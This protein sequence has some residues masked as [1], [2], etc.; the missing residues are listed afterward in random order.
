MSDPIRLRPYRPGDEDGI[1]RCYNA[2]FPTAD[3][4]IRERAMASW[5]WRFLANPVPQVHH[6]VAEHEQEGIVGGYAGIPVRVWCEGEE[7]LATQNVDLMVL[8]QWRRAGPRPGLFVSLGKLF[9]ETFCGVA[10]DKALFCYGWPVPAWRMG[11]A[12]LGYWN[13]RDWD[14]LF[15]EAGSTGFPLRPETAELVTTAVAKASPDVDALFAA[16]RPGFG[17]ALVRDAAY[18]NW[19]Y[20]DLFGHHYTILECRERSTGTLRG[21]AV[22]TVGDL[23]RPHTAFLVDWLAPADDHA[24]TL[25]LVSAAERLAMRD[26]TGVLATMFSHVDPRFLPFQR[27][28]FHVLGTSY[29][30]VVASFHHDTLFFREKWYYT[31]G[32][33]DLI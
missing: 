10:K 32:D 18:L 6:V 1:L 16:L 15:R 22:Y 29:F 13:I 33:S 7:R 21:L 30:I 27:L 9:H 26:G 12:Y 5:K 20:A 3:G 19:R 28:G 8:P 24:A 4:R 23:I 31:M 14:L 11:Q 25:S 17:L 2:I